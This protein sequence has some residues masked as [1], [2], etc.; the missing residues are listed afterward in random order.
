MNEKKITIGLA[1]N[2]NTGKTSI[3]NALSG[4]RQKT[5]NYPGV[6]VEKKETTKVY[7]DYTFH[8]YDIPG[9]YSLSAYSIDEMIARDFIIDE[10]PDVIIDVLDSTNFSRNLYLLLEFKELNVP[11]IA[12]LNMNDQAKSIGINIDEKKLSELISMPV[13]KTVG[14]KGENV[15]AIFDYAIE[16]FESGNK[17]YKTEET[18]IN[19]GLMIEDEILKI[20]NILSENKD[21]KYSI[22]WLA[23][24]LLEKDI[25]ANKKINDLDNRDILLSEVDKSIKTLENHHKIDS[26]IIMSEQRYAYING[27]SKEVTK[28]SSHNKETITEKIDKVIINRVLGLPIFLFILWAVFQITFTLGAYPQGWLEMFFGAVSDLAR[29]ALPSGSLL[30]SLIV[31]GVI[32]GLGAVLSFVP[33]IIILFLCISFLE[34]I[35]YMSRA[36]FIVDKFLHTFGLHG[37]SFF[38]M[39]LGFGCSIPAI[40][41]AR[42]LKSRK[43]Q[44]ITIFAIPFMSCGAKLPVYILLTGAFF[45]DNPGNVVMVIYFIGVIISLLTAKVFSKVLKKKDTPFVMELPLYRT[46]T[47]KSLFWNVWSKTFSYLKRAGTVLLLAAILVWAI[48]TFPTISD[49]KSEMVISEATELYLLENENASEEE[50]EEHVNMAVDNAALS[51]SIAGTIG[52]VFEPV[53]APLGFD[54]KIGISVITGFAAKE[55]VV[56]TLGVLY[57]VGA[58]DEDEYESLQEILR[59][60][61]NFNALVGFVL[62]LV[63]L[64]MTPCV[65][66]I[67]VVK[68]EL[69]WKWFMLF[70]GY[71]VSIAWIVGTI[72]Y[73]V[74]S[75]IEPS[76]RVF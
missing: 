66:A 18:K 2:P 72:V 16:I 26:E 38:P 9:T 47:L 6:T 8:I 59:K 65:G 25:I 23:I 3:F 46:P 48:T 68:S 75:L 62:M 13:V 5:G 39:M 21:L 64:F 57:N 11:M 69:G 58:S 37:Q 42:T 36:A 17:D 22:R 44:I 40:M 73:Q 50:L 71:T 51:G 30:E 20:V 74:G 43:D 54:W 52:K 53:V 33:L 61:P 12:V 70:I 31:D 29:L 32:G 34:D 45:P 76:L 4:A 28:Q 15:N 60:D 56:S 49:K 1:G 41:A 14:S 19:Y 10:K 55:V 24:K 67:A 27:I 7:K 35:G 63:T